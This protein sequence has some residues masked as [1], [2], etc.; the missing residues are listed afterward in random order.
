VTQREAFAGRA[1]ISWRAFAQRFSSALLALISVALI[2][3]GKIDGGAVEQVR[4]R[5]A[6]AAA[7]LLGAIQRPVAT[8]RDSI[9]NSQ[10]L[11][12]LAHENAMLRA[13]NARLQE[14]HAA[15]L[16]LEAQNE[17][18]RA[19][20]NLAPATAPVLKTE[21]IIGEP[22]GLYVRSILIAGG[23]HDGLSRGQAA[24]VGPGLVGRITE[25]GAVSARV[26]LITDLNSRVPVILE[27][28]RT[29]AI[30]AGDN[31]SRPYLLYL[32]KAASVNIGDRVVTAG[33]DGVFPT[34]LAIGKIVSIENGEIRVEPIAD[35]ERLEYVSVV[36]SVSASALTP[37]AAPAMDV[38]TPTA[39]RW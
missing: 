10:G 30:L 19:M 1:T 38:H 20:A 32:P 22:G 16:K 26:L 3:F 39:M 15:A 28:T 13:E 6:D 35:L 5:T 8:I 14:W 11:F 23:A 37:E 2:V 27:G 9:A 25:L 17:V 21:P 33:H 4:S 7:P 36:D 31:S 29:H 18:L 24:M 12:D 34:G